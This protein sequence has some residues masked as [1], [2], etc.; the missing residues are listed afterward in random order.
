MRGERERLRELV[1]I[2]L[3]GVRRV[4]IF[5]QDAVDVRGGNRDVIEQSLRR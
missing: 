1:F 4:R 5:A 2:Q 3:R